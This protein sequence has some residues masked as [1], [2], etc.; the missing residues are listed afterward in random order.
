MLSDRKFFESGRTILNY[1]KSLFTLYKSL[2][3]QAKQLGEFIHVKR[4][5]I[6]INA[7]I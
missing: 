3:N 1:K 6:A 5:R 2:F 4:S 7:W